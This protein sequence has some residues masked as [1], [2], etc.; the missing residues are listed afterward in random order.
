MAGK[1]LADQVEHGLDIWY[2]SVASHPHL[3]HHLSGPDGQPDAGCL[4]TVRARFGRWI[5][6]T[7]TRPYDRAW[8]DH[9][10]EIGL[11][12]HRARKNLVRHGVRGAPARDA[13]PPRGPVS[14]PHG[15]HR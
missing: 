8:L 4:D 15:S 10:E 12:H 5:L 1:V 3:L 14:L 6:G 13:A 11:R 2:G 9:A 7:C